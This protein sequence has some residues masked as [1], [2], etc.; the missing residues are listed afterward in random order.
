MKYAMRS[1]Y[2]KK[3]VALK[4]PAGSGSK[5]IP[6]RSGSTRAS[7]SVKGV[8]ERART[9]VTD[10]KAVRLGNASQPAEDEVMAAVEVYPLAVSNQNLIV[11]VRPHEPVPN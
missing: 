1:K 7:W 11:P 8:P 9:M 5:R 3:R 4:V 2:L 10:D 6:L